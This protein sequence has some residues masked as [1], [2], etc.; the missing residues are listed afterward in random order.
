M[1]LK[2]AFEG[3]PEF[4]QGIFL[5]TYCVQDSVVGNV[6]DPCLI[7]DGVHFLQEFDQGQKCPCLSMTV[8]DRSTV[9]DLTLWRSWCANQALKYKY[10]YSRQDG[11]DWYSKKRECDTSNRKVLD[12]FRGSWSRLARVHLMNGGK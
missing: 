8:Y 10:G 3:L 7:Y 4:L 9:A 2:G 5:Y 1:R 6:K 11:E 12:V